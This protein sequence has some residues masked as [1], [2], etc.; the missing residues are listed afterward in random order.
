[1]K[2]SHKPKA[3]E[4]LAENLQAYLSATEE[5]GGT[6]A[7]RKGPTQK[8]IWNVVHK[9]HKPTLATLEKISKATGLE[10]FQLLMPMHDKDFLEI[11]WAYNET[12]DRGRETLYDNAKILREK[13]RRGDPQA[14]EA[15]DR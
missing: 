12:D 15:D 1:M 14:D 7:G 8:T 6:V 5:T 10:I 2:N 4:T 11:C 13:L 3:L 9:K